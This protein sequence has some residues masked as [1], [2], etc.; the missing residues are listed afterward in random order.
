MD[1]HI[2][3]CQSLINIGLTVLIEYSIPFI[4][5]NKKCFLNHNSVASY[6]LMCASISLFGGGGGGEV[7]GGCN[8][9]CKLELLGTE[10]GS[11]S[12]CGPNRDLSKLSKAVGSVGNPRVLVSSPA[13]LYLYMRGWGQEY[14]YC[15]VYILLSRGRH[16][17]Q[18]IVLRQNMVRQKSQ[19]N[20]TSQEI[21]FPK[22]LNVC[23]TKRQDKISWDKNALE[24]KYPRA[25]NVHTKHPREETCFLYN[26]EFT[27]NVKRIC[28]KTSMQEVLS[29]RTS[30][31]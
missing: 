12:N 21:D 19:G 15:T 17:T 23:R 30:E 10:D 7:S 8:T 3:I 2:I 24:T 25:Q 22:R 27:S 13:D 18:Q 9:S 5:D 26:F 11:N 29:P 1:V 6:T 28:L 14:T 20:R 16:G 4:L 31:C